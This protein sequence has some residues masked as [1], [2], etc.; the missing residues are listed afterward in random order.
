MDRLK[1]W[2][3]LVGSVAIHGFVLGGVFLLA[4][5]LERS[6]PE[7]LR[8][9]IAGA[10]GNELLGGQAVMAVDLVR[11][12]FPR[13][14]A[15]HEE[16][17]PR[18][19]SATTT[20]QAT[21]RGE[22]AISLDESVA[23]DGLTQDVKD[24]FSQEL[25]Q[26]SSELVQRNSG[27]SQSS[28]LMQGSSGGGAVVDGAAGGL[29]GALVADAVTG[30]GGAAEARPGDLAELIQAVPL[31]AAVPTLP[32]ELASK[33]IGG[34]TVKLQVYVQKS[35]EVTEVNLLHSSGIESLD[36]AAMEA[37]ERLRYTPAFLSGVPTASWTEVEISF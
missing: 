18:V 14:S 26:G 30:P 22:S 33:R 27:S 2:H 10:S 13:G 6:N 8:A 4:S 19:A 11:G 25:V 17:V 23:G 37:A 21:P 35:G 12:G 5:L 32:R 36:Q 29:G 7:V 16:G 31:Y 34:A 28:R 3:A 9:G 24:G 15:L 20:G 1:N